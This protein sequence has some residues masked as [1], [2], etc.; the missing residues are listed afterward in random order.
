VLATASIALIFLIA[1][2]AAADWQ[3]MSTTFSI[4]I[5]S[6][7]DNIQYGVYMYCNTIQGTSTCGSMQTACTSSQGGA[8]FPS[9]SAV[10]A[11][12]AF[13]VLSILVLSGAVLLMILSMFLGKP[14]FAKFVLI[15][16]IVTCVFSLLTWACYTK[17]QQSGFTLGAGFALTIVAML[18]C[19]GATIL[20]AHSIKMLPG[21]NFGGGTSTTTTTTT[22]K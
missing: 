20:W 3:H 22:T 1:A 10:Q 4:G 8:N 14:E 21:A 5:L 2:A 6:F 12:Q 7:T 11:S 19:I 9:C 16:L 17:F 13:I 18:F 15:P